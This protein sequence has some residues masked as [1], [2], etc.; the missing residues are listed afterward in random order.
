LR[1]EVSRN[2]QVPIDRRLHP[3]HQLAAQ[4]ATGPEAFSRSLRLFNESGDI[5]TSARII[6]IL[7]PHQLLQVTQICS[8]TSESGKQP[9]TRS[10]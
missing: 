2:G 9:I 1:L 8:A 7:R 10:E 3:N 4:I 6:Q 5:Q